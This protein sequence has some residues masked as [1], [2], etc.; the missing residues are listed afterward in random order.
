MKAVIQRVRHASV[1][2][3]GETKGKIEN[4]WLVLLGVKV[5]DSQKDSAYLANKIAGL[6]AFPDVEGKMNFS[7]TDVSGQILVVSQFTLYGDCRKGKRPSFTTSA[8]GEEAEKNYEQFVE[9]L[10]NLG[11]KVATGVFGAKMQVSLENDG[12]VTFILES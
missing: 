8:S 10:K 9:D 2:V 3:E 4:G 1:T 12:P 6:R 7:V 5:G 11:I